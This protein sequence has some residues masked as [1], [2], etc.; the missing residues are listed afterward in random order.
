VIE[1]FESIAFWHW[2]V[3]GVALAA[4]EILMPGS[5]LLWLGIAAGVVGIVVL[6]FPT[7]GWE[8]QMVLFAILSVASILGGRA[9][10]KRMATPESETTLNRR[11]EQF[12]G[13]TFVLA[14]AIEN[15]RGAIHAGDTLWRVAGPDRPTGAK[16]R[17]V[18]S[19][20]ALLSVEPVD[21]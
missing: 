10:I 12:V 21:E 16:V 6:V 20:G 13:R 7:I 3:L 11:G 14:E 2:F 19:D 9:V 15:G 18:S 5:F 17:V 1:Y 4:I 8:L